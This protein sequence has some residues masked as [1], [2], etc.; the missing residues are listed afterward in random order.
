MAL[1]RRN[2][3]AGIGGLAAAHT[4]L[5]GLC[6]HA[7]QSAA[8]SAKP[9]IDAAKRDFGIP[10][11]ITFLNSAYT[12]PMPLAARDALRSWADFRATPQALSRPKPL[13]NLKAEFAALI[14]ARINARL[15]PQFLR[16]SPS[17]FNDLA[18][19]DR[20]LEALS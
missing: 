19:I 3:L 2:L 11:E 4:T 10:S 13:I 12:H 17:V 5:G 6:A 7:L 18:D 14:N 1:T 20:L 16:L 9:A 15:S 8:P